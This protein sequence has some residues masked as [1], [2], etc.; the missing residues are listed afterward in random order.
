MKYMDLLI[1]SREEES[2]TTI[3]DKLFSIIH[4]NDFK[5]RFSAHYVDEHYYVGENQNMEVKVMLSDDLGNLDLPFWLSL[6]TIDEEVDL[7]VDEIYKLIHSELI[8]SGFRVA[9]M[10]KFGQIGEQRID[11]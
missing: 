8:P 3:A 6:S 7:D 11:Y 9:R 10:E 4:I 5:E 1:A 2:L